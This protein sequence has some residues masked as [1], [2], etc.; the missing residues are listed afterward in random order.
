MVPGG[1]THYTLDG[2][3][4]DEGSSLYKSPF[5]VPLLNHQPV[6]LNVIVVTPSGRRSVV[7]GATLLRRP[8]KPAV[9]RGDRKPGLAYTLFEG[10]FS[11]T[12]DLEAAVPRAAGRA[13]SVD[14]H[15]FGR[16]EDYGVIFKGYLNVP[17]D[18]FYQFASE[19]DDGSMLY[20]DDEEVVANDWEHGRYL[21]S[22][23]LPLA[24]GL[25][26]IRIEYFQAGGDSGLQVLWAISGQKLKAIEPSALFH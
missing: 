13:D 17:A 22:G 16:E 21:V 19:S 18:G 11:T 25:H 8:L 20:I 9:P 23:H 10:R 2:T 3:N 14:H 24:K 4:P 26:R 12:K 5:R 6:R 1:R 15:R 7:Y